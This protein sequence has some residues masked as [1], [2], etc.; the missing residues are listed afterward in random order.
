MLSRVSLT[1]NELRISSMYTKDVVHQLLGEESI[2]LYL[3]N[4]SA[5]VISLYLMEN[6]EV[7]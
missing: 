6:V 7:C 1:I 4:D 3:S 2:N 5:F